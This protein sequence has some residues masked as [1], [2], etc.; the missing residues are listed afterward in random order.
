VKKILRMM[1]LLSATGAV[2]NAATYYVAKTGSD[3]NPGTL[4]SPWLTISHAAGVVFAGDTVM[5]EDGTYTESLTLTRGGTSSS[6]ITFQAQNKWGAVIAPTA[7]TSDSSVITVGGQY[8]TIKNFE[9][10]T[11]NQNVAYGIRQSCVSQCGDGLV[12]Q[13]NKI[14]HIDAGTGA[15]CNAGAAV[16]PFTNST[17]DGNLIYDV[18]PP[19]TSS[20]CYH[21]HGIY[22]QGGPA[23]VTNNI[24]Y[25]IWQGFAVQ[26]AN[27]QST[28]SFNNIHIV[29]N[30]AF[31]NGAIVG[32]VQSGGSIYLGCP[33]STNG[34]QCND[35]VIANNILMDN[36]PSGGVCFSNEYEDPALVRTLTNNIRYNCG[37]TTFASGS[38]LSWTKDST[39]NPLLV[40]YVNDGSGNYH[41]TSGSPAIG[42]GTSLDAPAIDYDGLTRLQSYDIGAYEYV[43]VSA[44][45]APTGLA[46]TVN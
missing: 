16:G 12:V 19:R 18:S 38:N 30:L 5:V 22:G 29:N 45:A 3:S 28:V 31:N 23:T 27:A 33:S 44:P 26:E 9:I 1:I 42:A 21:M 20:S 41:L 24:I 40:N 43:V 10:T 25:E 32:G 15:P 37:S 14:H 8:I 6:R 39:A 36:A 7:L 11:S 34:N 35:W 4:A 17:V 46:A 13:G 2:A